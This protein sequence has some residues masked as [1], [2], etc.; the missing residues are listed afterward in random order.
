MLYN[1]GRESLGHYPFG[2]IDD[3]ETVEEIFASDGA[4]ALIG[5]SVK[6]RE[7]CRASCEYF[8]LCGGGC[9]DVA[10]LSGGL[11][12]IPADDCY[13]FKTV[14]AHVERVFREVMEKRVPLSDLNPMVKGILARTLTKTSTTTKNDLADTYL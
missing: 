13:L 5:G 3:F 4:L 7:K 11:E 2:S 12:E 6:R 8:S 9:A 10:I 1:C 14:Y